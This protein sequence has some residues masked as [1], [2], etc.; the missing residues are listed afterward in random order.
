M[1]IVL[2][3][4][5]YGNNKNIKQFMPPNWQKNPPPSHHRH[6]DSAALLYPI[7]VYIHNKY[8]QYKCLLGSTFLP[9]YDDLCIE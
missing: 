6:I 8:I 1:Y 9:S 4:S 3:S 5:C 7:N 2:F